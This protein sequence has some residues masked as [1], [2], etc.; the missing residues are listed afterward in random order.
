[1]V[2]KKMSRTKCGSYFLRSPV[3][4]KWLWHPIDG[5]QVNGMVRRFTQPKLG[6]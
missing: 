2:R 5:G 1:M 4:N 3:F 6:L